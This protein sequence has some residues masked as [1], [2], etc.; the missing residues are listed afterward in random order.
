MSGFD[1]EQ[2]LRIGFVIDDVDKID[3]INAMLSDQQVD[4]MLAD[5]VELKLW[6]ELADQLEHMSGERI[7]RFAQ[8]FAAAP[9]EVRSGLR[10]AAGAGDFDAAALTLLDPVM[11][12]DDLGDDSDTNGDSDAALLVVV[13]GPRVES[14]HR[15][16][17]VLLDADGGVELAAGDVHAPVYPRSSL[18]PLQTVAMLASGFDG[19]DEWVAMAS[20]SHNGQDV[21]RRTVAAILRAAGLDDTALQCPPALPRDEPVMLEWVRSGHG[22]ARIC[23]NCSGKHAAKLATCQSAGWDAGSYLDPGHPL[24]REIVAQI[25]RLSGTQIAATSVDG[26]GAPAHALPLIGLARAFAAVAGAASGTQAHRVAA[27]MQT[28]PELVGGTGRAVTELM[29]EVPGLVAKD[30]AEGVWGAALADGRAFAAKT[31]DGSAR[32]LGPLLAAALSHWGFAGPAVRRWSQVD[33]LGGGHPVGA[34]RWSDDLQ[35][36]LTI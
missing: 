10:D 16:R 23:H 12:P 29:D 36:L 5:A 22:P 28:H 33:V 27:A 21:H 32:A 11:S 34:V 25:E 35:A 17:V 30:G 19:P 6:A 31:S 18:K 15:G 14:W 3:M 4:S 13:R 1:G 8:R 24:Q 2:L 20:A 9:E 26:C 7:D